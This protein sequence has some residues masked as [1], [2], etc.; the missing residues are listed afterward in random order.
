MRLDHRQVAH[1][2]TSVLSHTGTGAPT[3]NTAPNRRTVVALTAATACGAL[4]LAACGTPGPAPQLYQLRAA[5][6]L[7]VV[8]VKTVHVVQVVGGVQLPEL[9]D[10][11][12]LLLPQGLAGVQALASHRWAEPLRDALPRVLRQDLAALLGDAQVWAAPVPPGVIIT[13]Q[14]RVEV[15]AMQPRAD[16]GTA[17]LQV[18][19]SLADPIGVTQVK[20]STL[21]IEVPTSNAQPDALVNAY[22]QALWRLAETIAKALG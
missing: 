7:P 9:L 4:L 18:R 2:S 20:V 8:P 5:P 21:Q 16:C 13:R 12:S 10:N 14:L 1:P 15:L 17:Q 19:Y 6:P 3:M 22:R 11:S